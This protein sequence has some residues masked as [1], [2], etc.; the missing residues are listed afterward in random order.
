MDTIEKALLAL[1]DVFNSISKKEM[2]RII[3]KIDN[4]NKKQHKYKKNKKLH[5]AFFITLFL[6]Q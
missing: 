1:D 2:S 6:L 3:N 4:L 5:R